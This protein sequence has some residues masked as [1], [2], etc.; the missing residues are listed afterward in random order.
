MGISR[1]SLAAHQRFR[2]KQ[3]LPFPLLSDQDGAVCRLYGV[4]YPKG[5]KF[6]LERSTFLIDAAGNLQRV[7]RKVKV[8]GH[9]A[10]VLAAVQQTS[11]AT[12]ER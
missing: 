4:L 10:E 8:A 11:P 7:W 9:A 5:E 12:G 3:E 6:G 2:E 1:D